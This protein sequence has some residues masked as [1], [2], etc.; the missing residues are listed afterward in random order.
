MSKTLSFLLL[1]SLLTSCS[2]PLTGNKK[3]AAIN[4]DDIEVTQQ[5][6]QQQESQSLIQ[7][8]GINMLRSK[9]S[10]NEAVTE[11]SNIQ[12]AFDSF[13]LSESAMKQLK[14][15]AKSLN[16]DKQTQ[17]LVAGHCDARGTKDYNLI[18]GEKRAIAVKNFLVNNGVAKSRIQ[19]ISYGE[20]RPLESAATEEAYGINRRAEFTFN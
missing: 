5:Q 15:L 3:N 14:D 16:E 2:T 4:S 12:F 18:L 17:I 19:T 20:E 13:Q 1:I 10:N 11:S 6:Q 9:S 8:V 7:K